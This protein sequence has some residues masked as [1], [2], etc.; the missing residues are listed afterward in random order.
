MRVLQVCWL[1]MGRKEGV[2]GPS[3]LPAGERTRGRSEGFSSLQAG[4]GS[5]GMSEAY[6]NWN[7]PY[8]FFF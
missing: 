4:E 7:G 3:S 1:V 6:R 5:R 2:R 8:K